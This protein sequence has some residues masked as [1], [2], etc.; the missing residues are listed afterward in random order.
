MVAHGTSIAISFRLKKEEQVENIKAMLDVYGTM[1]MA[2]MLSLL[3][4]GIAGIV[5]G[6]MLSWWSEWWLWVSIVLLVVITIWMFTI[7]QGTYHQLRRTLGMPFQAGSKE[8]PA[9]DPAPVEES[10]A[11]IAK[12][13]PHLMMLA[14]Y[15]GFVVIIWLMMFKPF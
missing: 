12:K 7:G 11:L 8:M 9:Q 14:G 10:Y 5:L 3:V 15:G 2:M 1:W 6:F 13:K 4:V